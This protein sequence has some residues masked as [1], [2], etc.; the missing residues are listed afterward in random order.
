MRS[1]RVS[2]AVAMVLFLS[3]SA[4]ATVLF[5]DGFEGV[6]PPAIGPAPT[7][8]SGDWQFNLGSGEAMS[9]TGA[10]GGCPGAAT[11]SNYLGVLQGGGAVWSTANAGFPLQSNPADLV[12]FE[13]DIFGGGAAKPYIAILPTQNASN[14]ELNY[15]LLSYNGVVYVPGGSSLSWAT[16]SWHHVTMDYHPT[17]ST[18]DLTIDSQ[19][20]QKGIAMGAAGSVAGFE[21]SNAATNAYADYDNVKVTLIAGVPEP[22]SIVLLVSGLAGLVAYAWRKRK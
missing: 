11:G 3:T 20:T 10:L 18:F 8:P 19:P 4:F 21:L 6:T 22:T 12:R 1:L 7:A 14:N 17:A 13:A 16:G 2:L 5:E 9:L 15:V